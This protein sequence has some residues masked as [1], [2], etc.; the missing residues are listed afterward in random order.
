MNE[1]KSERVQ[2]RVTPT[3]KNEF[4]ATAELYGLTP[5]VLLESLMQAMV[6]AAKKHPGRVVFPLEINYYPED[7][8]NAQE[9]RLADHSD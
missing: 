4:E 8:P 2:P 5:N 7:S 1:K 3:L 9:R 6:D